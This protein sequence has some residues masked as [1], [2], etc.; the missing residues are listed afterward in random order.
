[1]IILLR[2]ELH[3]NIRGEILRQVPNQPELAPTPAQRLQLSQ[4]YSAPVSHHVPVSQVACEIQDRRPDAGQLP[5]EVDGGDG[6]EDLQVA[7][8]DAAQRAGVLQV[9]Q[10]HPAQRGALE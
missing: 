10:A 5:D 6:E 4:I 1:M 9:C 7:R 2:E 3:P 8:G